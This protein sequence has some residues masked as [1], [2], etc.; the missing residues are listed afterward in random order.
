LDV[1]GHALEKERARQRYGSILRMKNQ[2]RSSAHQLILA[3]KSA[4]NSA[5]V[6][7]RLY[8]EL[9]SDYNK[10]LPHLSGN[11]EERLRRSLDLIRPEMGMTRLD[12]YFRSNLP[13]N[14]VRPELSALSQLDRFAAPLRAIDPAMPAYPVSQPN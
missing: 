3:C 13:I 4:R 5:T 14:F 6:A 11:L 12:E 10:L 7:D 8:D 1:V 9:E 2:W